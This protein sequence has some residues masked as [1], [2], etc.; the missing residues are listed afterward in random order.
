MIKKK[1]YVHSGHYSILTK[2]NGQW[3][4]LDDENV[5]EIRG[6]INDWI[7]DKFLKGN[8]VTACYSSHLTHENTTLKRKREEKTYER[9]LKDGYDRG[10]INEGHGSF[11]AS[12]FNKVDASTASYP[13]IEG[14]TR[15]KQSNNEKVLKIN[16][17]G[18][19]DTVQEGKKGNVLAL[20]DAKH[21]L[22]NIICN[23]YNTSVSLKS[24]QSLK[25]EFI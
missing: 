5:E 15:Q 18:W 16:Y 7:G 3:F 1:D 6:N 23:R 25:K 20:L 12:I 8:I 19:F 9:I 10:V 2:W 11:V 4:H 13:I 17:E 14:G 21:D 22:E 24:F